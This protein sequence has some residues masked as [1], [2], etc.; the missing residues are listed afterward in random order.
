[1]VKRIIKLCLVNS[2][3]T[4][5]IRQETKTQSRFISSMKNVPSTSRNTAK[6]EYFKSD[7]LNVT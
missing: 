5:E 7:S 2:D 1:M 6:E 4:S 3:I